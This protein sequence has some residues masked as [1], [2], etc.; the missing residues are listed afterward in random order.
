MNNSTNN[1]LFYRLG[2]ALGQPL[3]WVLRKQRPVVTW[4]SDMG[5][6]V[7]FAK[8]L[9]TIINLAILVGLLFAFAPTWVI[10]FVI[11]ITILAYKGMDTNNLAPQQDE[12]EWQMGW[13]GSGLY[14]SLG[15]RVDCGSIEDEE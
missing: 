1:T 8:R 15:S 9:L 13:D 14:N 11:S 4:L 6:P 7:P 10:L 5:L 3:A 12:Y 2:K